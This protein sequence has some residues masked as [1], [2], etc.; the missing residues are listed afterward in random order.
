MPVLMEPFS[1]SSEPPLMS[2]N[3]SRRVC[4][5]SASRL[6]ATLH[7]KHTWVLWLRH[8]HATDSSLSWIR[9]RAALCFTS[10]VLSE[11]NTRLGRWMS[12]P[13]SISPL[14]QCKSVTRECEAVDAYVLMCMAC[15][16]W[17]LRSALASR[18]CLVTICPLPSRNTRRVRSYVLPPCGS[19]L[20]EMLD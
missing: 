2:L 13:P 10:N 15:T 16:R 3:T 4:A 18:L 7:A 20:P 8:Q 17:R 19:K 9:N 14:H 1:W 12:C 11:L 5:S 6:V